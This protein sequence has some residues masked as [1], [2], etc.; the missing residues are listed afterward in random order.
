MMTS[1]VICSNVKR[2][3]GIYETVA[4]YKVVLGKVLLECPYVEKC[5][6]AKLEICWNIKK[7]HCYV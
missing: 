3:V 6:G 1:C 4:F 5:P 2:N 7:R